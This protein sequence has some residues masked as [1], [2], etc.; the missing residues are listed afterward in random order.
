MK[1]NFIKEQIFIKN[2]LFLQVDSKISIFY[3]ILVQFF[4]INILIRILRQKL[5]Q[6]EIKL[7]ES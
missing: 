3:F 2:N 4:L 7:E 1:L 6:Q 5:N